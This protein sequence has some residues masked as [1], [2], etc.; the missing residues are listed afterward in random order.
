MRLAGVFLAILLIAACPPRRARVVYVVPARPAPVQPAVPVMPQPTPPGPIKSVL[1][2]LM[3]LALPSGSGGVCQTASAGSF[4]RP[5][6]VPMTSSGRVEPVGVDVF[7]GL[8]LLQADVELD[9]DRLVG[10]QLVLDLVVDVDGRNRRG[11]DEQ[12]CEQP[13][14]EGPRPAWRTGQSAACCSG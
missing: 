13:R 9:R 1:A 7:N 10:I 14:P 11:R 5:N 2:W 6:S 12:E 8:L 3:P 4:K